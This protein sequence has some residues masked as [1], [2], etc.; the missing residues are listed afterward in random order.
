MR[1]VSAEQCWEGLLAVVTEVLDELGEDPGEL[2][3]TTMT[4]ADL[5]ISSVEAIHIAVMLENELRIRLNFESLA[6]RD[7][8]YVEDLSLGEWH[9]FLVAS[10]GEVRRFR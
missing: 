2:T 4:Y 10:A 6:V 7:G 5:G 1:R 8:E 3:R 9:D